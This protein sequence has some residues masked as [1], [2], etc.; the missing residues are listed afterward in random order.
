MSTLHP[1]TNKHSN[2][3]SICEKIIPTSFGK[4][5]WIIWT[6][7]TFLIGCYSDW[8]LVQVS[9]RGWNAVWEN[10][11]NQTQQTNKV[12]KPAAAQ[13]PATVST[14]SSQPP[15]CFLLRYHRRAKKCGN[16]RP[17]QPSQILFS[18]LRF[19]KILLRRRKWCGW[20][21]KLLQHDI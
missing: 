12:N 19:L 17:S 10:L 7:G 15:K 1:L 9:V 21:L 11:D 8:L 6:I 2:I 13:Q 3:T 20:H 4:F 18:F 5:K 14:V 16:R